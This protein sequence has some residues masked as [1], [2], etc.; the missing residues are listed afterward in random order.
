MLIIVPYVDGMLQPKTQMTPGAEF[1]ELPADDP[2][3]YWR[4]IVR[5]YEHGDD[6]CI[7]EHDIVISR[8]Q[9][10]S[11][12][13]CIE[14]WCAYGY[15]RGGAEMVALGVMRLKSWV[16]AQYPNLLRLETPERV[17]FDQCDGT[18][19]GKLRAINLTV[20]RHSPDVGHE[21]SA[22]RVLHEWKVSREPIVPYG[23]SATAERGEVWT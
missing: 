8:E 14:P 18:L 19:Y 15:K 20:H 7:V 17:F 9:L 11:L 12:D 6:F 23:S 2:Y 1:V 5:L 22:M 16:M 10:D 3:A 4:L 13:E 21:Q